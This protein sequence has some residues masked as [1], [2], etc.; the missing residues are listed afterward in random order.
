MRLLTLP[1]DEPLP[2]LVLPEMAAAVGPVEAARRYRAIVLVTLRQLK[3]LE[4]CRLRLQVEPAD[5]NEAVRF[6]ILPKL[7][8]R[9]ES[10]GDVFRSDGWEI[11][12]GGAN[13]GF[14]VDARGDI[15]CPWLG[16]R[17]VHAGLLGM[18]RS[19]GAVIG[20]ARGGGNYFEARAVGAPEEL[21]SRM[22]PELPV[23]RND[24]DW[25]DALESALG[26]ALKKVWKAEG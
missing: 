7:A 6:W 4:N 25:N 26:A 9:W 20:P 1:I 15:L 11:D 12:F 13:E 23:I 16:A 5:A 18:G 24:A 8:D 2:G 21:P 17:W 19:V 14:D 22:L 3:G 10:D